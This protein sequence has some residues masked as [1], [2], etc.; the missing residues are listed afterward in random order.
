MKLVT[1]NETSYQKCNQLA[2]LIK[3]TKSLKSYQQ[4]GWSS[5]CFGNYRYSTPRQKV[6]DG[7][8]VPVPDDP[9]RRLR[10]LLRP[11]RQVD[12]TAVLHQH[13]PVA[14]DLPPGDWNGTIRMLRVPM[15]NLYMF[16][17]G[18]ENGFKLFSKYN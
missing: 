14:K 13:V 10:G 3:V 11:T 4:I 17:V 8:G 1:K 9:L 7:N 6:I 5:P 15:H 2:N 12:V 16:F 18:K